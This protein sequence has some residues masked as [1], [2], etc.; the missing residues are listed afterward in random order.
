M[1]RNWE[2]LY[3]YTS[4]DTFM[5]I[6]KTKKF[7]LYDVTKSND[8]LEGTYMLQALENT[9]QSLYREE[10]ISKDECT[11]AHRAFFY[12][13]EELMSQGRFKDFCGAAS[14]CVPAH[15]L[16]MLRSY[17]GNGKGVALG[18]PRKTLETLSKNN[19]QLT[20]K[21]MEYLSAREVDYRATDFWLEK[22]KFWKTKVSDIDEE[23]L[24]PLINEI[25][26]YY[27][28]SYFLKDKVNEDEEEYRL[29][30]CCEDLFELCLP[31]IG[32]AVS[33]DIDFISSNGDL[34]AYYEIP[35][36][37][38][39]QAQF[40]FSDVVIG[41]QCGAT[42]SEVQTFLCRYGIKGCN[43]SKNSWVQMR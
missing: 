14:F 16:L 40:Y 37:D 30:F 26:K 4:L 24:R 23:S 21:E 28:Q 11:L 31:G 5:N 36:G 9:Y 27:Y 20:F 25:K 32:K 13:K 2:V 34:K 18:V 39:D 6:I 12:F 38:R 3:H 41:P 1:K 19:Q 33:Q 29:L 42:I 15:E 22:I 10:K 7:R 17:A 43:V 35:I 8:P